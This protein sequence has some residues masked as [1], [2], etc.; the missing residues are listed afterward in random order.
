MPNVT[1]QE[2]LKAFSVLGIGN[3]F[4]DKH[5]FI[6]YGGGIITPLYKKIDIA[7]QIGS[8]DQIGYISMAL[9]KNF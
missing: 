1:I 4:G 3:Y 2:P 7:V 9:L 5:Y 8:A 6:D